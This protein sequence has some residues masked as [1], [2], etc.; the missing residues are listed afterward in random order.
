MCKCESCSCS[1]RLHS[2]EYADGQSGAWGRS[3]APNS[4]PYVGDLCLSIN[5]NY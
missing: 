5:I 4:I 1:S 3:A 2:A